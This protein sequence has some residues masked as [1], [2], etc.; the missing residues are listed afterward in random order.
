MALLGLRPGEL[1]THLLRKTGSG[2]GSLRLT[3][4]SVRHSSCVVCF[5]SVCTSA[6]DDGLIGLSS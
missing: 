4:T 5:S 6:S 3:L 1:I 2:L